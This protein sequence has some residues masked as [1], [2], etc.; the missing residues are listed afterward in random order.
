[1][2]FNKLA[3]AAIFFAFM[4]FSFNSWASTEKYEEELKSFIISDYIDYKNWSKE[5]DGLDE[6]AEFLKTVELDSLSENEFKALLI[7]AYN[8]GMIRLIIQNY[9]I[10]G[11]FDIVPEVFEQKT[12]NIG[13]RMLSLD[14]I[15]HNYLRKTGD[16]RI[17]FAIVCGSKGCPDLSSE[18]YKAESLEEQLDAA[19]RKYLSQSKGMVIERESSVVLLSMVFKWFGPD[20]GEIEAERLEV[21]SQYLPDDQAGFVRENIETV[22]LRYIEFDWSLNGD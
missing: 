6:Y 10:E 9:P 22:M 5:H 17:H 4:V 3:S 15:E 11:V 13:G 14:D 21:L 19:A 12:I 8:A 7:N 20:F 16:C 18:I 1:M 2:Q